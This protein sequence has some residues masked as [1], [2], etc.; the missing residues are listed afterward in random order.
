MT[1][2]HMAPQVPLPDRLYQGRVQLLEVKK[3]FQNLKL[4]PSQST[5]RFHLLAHHVKSDVLYSAGKLASCYQQQAC[6]QRGADDG[7][8]R[9]GWTED[10]CS[11]LHSDPATQP[12]GGGPGGNKPGR[13]WR[14]RK[15]S[16]AVFLS[17][18]VYWRL[19]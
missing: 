11:V 1:L 5:H 15:H 3:T 7:P 4:L 10:P 12:R 16:G 17:S 19:V 18:P 8:C 14:A 13:D 9:L 2:I 6:F